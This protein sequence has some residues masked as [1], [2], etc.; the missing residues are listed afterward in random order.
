MI[1]WIISLSEQHL[2]VVLFIKDAFYPYESED[3]F[4]RR[5]IQIKAVK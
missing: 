4:L 2:F 1:L 5:S 3:E